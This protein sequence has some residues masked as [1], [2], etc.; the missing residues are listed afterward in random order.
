MPDLDEQL[1]DLAGYGQRTGRLGSADAVRGRGDRRRRNQALGT[2]ALSVLLL[3]GAVSGGM[4]VTRPDQRTAP[5]VATPFT[6]PDTKRQYY[7]QSGEKLLSAGVDAVGGYP[8]GGDTGETELFHFAGP[9]PYALQTIRLTG[10]EPSCIEAKATGLI[11][12]NCDAEA[13]SQDVVI[14]PDGTDPQGRQLFGLSVGGRAVTM[15]E[16]G[17]VTT[18]DS[19]PTRFFLLDGGAHQDPFD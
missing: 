2:T 19:S 17:T 6:P 12:G 14:T 7:L 18:A 11:P 1:A 4:A 3:A 9:G 16:N 10:G 15:T 5:V 8:A 13:T